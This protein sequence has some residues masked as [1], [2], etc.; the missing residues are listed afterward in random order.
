VWWKCP[1]GVDHEWKAIVAN[2]VNGSTWPVCMGRKI[3]TTNNLL[4]LYPELKEEW[5]FEEN[6]D[7]DPRK[8]SP[9]SK[10]K[11]WWVCKRDPEHRWFAT[12]KDRT[13]KG[14]GCPYCAERLNVS[15]LQMLEIIKAAYPAE[16]VVYRA[17]PE[18]L[19]R[20][21]LDAY[22]PALGLAFEY[23]GQQHF[24]PVELFG[25]VEAYVKQVQRDRLKRELC[26]QRKIVLIEV[27]YDEPLSME[28]ILSKIDD[29]GMPAPFSEGSGTQPNAQAD[30]D[31]P[32]R[33]A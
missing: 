13:A 5:D 14:S 28:L 29:A 10:Q 1:E 32:R 31:K 30:A 6:A 19:Q 9:G 21:E 27:Y 3:T 20:L 16:E 7:I 8:T 23:Q 4:A 25:G 17:K 26:V 22:L 18:W 24:R 33:L 15:E 12:I 11:V 2:V